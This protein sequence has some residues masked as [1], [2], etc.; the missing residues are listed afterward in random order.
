MTEDD[1]IERI[2]KGVHN[3]LI[4]YCKASGDFSMKHWEEAE[5][6]QRED[7]IKM[8]RATLKGGHSA[9]EEHGRWFKNKMEQGYVYGPEKNDDTSKGPLTNPNM[10][11][12][13]ELPLY[14]RMKDDLMITVTIGLAAHYGVQIRREPELVWSAALS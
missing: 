6:W 3:V 5:D 9:A 8:V 11:P 12:Y 13:R 1:K 14:Q 4:T 2:A 7:T 10:L